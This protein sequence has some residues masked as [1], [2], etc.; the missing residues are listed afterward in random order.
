M[1]LRM[2]ILQHLMP[3]AAAAF[4]QTAAFANGP[5]VALSSEALASANNR[6]ASVL[7]RGIK[8]D[9]LRSLNILADVDP[10]TFTA[11]R[12]AVIGRQVADALAVIVGDQI[13]LIDPNGMTTPLGIAPQ[14]MNYNVA[15]IIEMAPSTEATT[16][17]YVSPEAFEKLSGGAR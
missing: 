17:I 14:I 13:R 2:G 7:V 16:S 3:I 6:S 12:S 15:A 10:A 8:V 1:A 11:G 5:T 9:D 4:L